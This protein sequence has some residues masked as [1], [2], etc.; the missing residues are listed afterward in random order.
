[1]IDP[2]MKIWLCLLINDYLCGD[3]IVQYST[4]TFFV[5]YLCQ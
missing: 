2:L 3:K 4:Y 1:M 5:L